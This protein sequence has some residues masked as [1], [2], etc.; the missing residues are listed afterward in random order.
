M[1]E[2]TIVMNKHGKGK[3]KRLL[4]AIAI[5][6]DGT[7]NSKVGNYEYALSHS[8]KYINKK[9]MY[10]KGKVKGFKRTD[11]VYKLLAMILK[12]AGVE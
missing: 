11:S 8:G 6:N 7:G 2:V 4:A 1:I 3:E 10:K 12:D 5:A 9:G